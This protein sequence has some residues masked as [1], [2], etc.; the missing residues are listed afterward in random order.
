[1]AIRYISGGYINGQM[2][3]TVLAFKISDLS[4]KW[5]ADMNHARKRHGSTVAGNKLYVIGSDGTGIASRTIEF[6]EL[7]FM[8]S[9][10]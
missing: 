5:V 7:D 2:S 8:W 10:C 9:E 1:M 3:A 6:L 4:F